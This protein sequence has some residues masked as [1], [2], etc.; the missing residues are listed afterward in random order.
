MNKNIAIYCKKYHPK[1]LEF[2]YKLPSNVIGVYD[3]LYNQASY[4]LPKFHYTDINNRGYDIIIDDLLLYE[5]L[6][7]KN[8]RIIYYIGNQS[9]N[10]DYQ[11]LFSLIQK[12]DAVILPKNTSN[13]LMEIVFKYT[14]ELIYV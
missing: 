14:G 10:I 5:R 1:L 9:N 6:K 7:D 4:D 11:K 12:I 2:L 13:D 8:N 3:D